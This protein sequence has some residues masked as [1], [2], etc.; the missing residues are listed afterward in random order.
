MNER[1]ES[2]WG[3]R[4]NAKNQHQCH[5]PFRWIGAHVWHPHAHT[6][7]KGKTVKIQLSCHILCSRLST[8]ELLHPI[9]TIT[10]AFYQIVNSTEAW[11]SWTLTHQTHI[12][13]SDDFSIYVLCCA[14]SVF[15]IIIYWP[16]SLTSFLCRPYKFQ[17]KSQ[18]VR[19]FRNQRHQTTWNWFLIRNE[20]RR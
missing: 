4:L 9:A 1:I 5:C 13:P 20:A 6:H 11:S 14:V 16:F 18:C 8:I 12:Q 10:S 3:A 7:M 15:F 19:H 17:S 2:R